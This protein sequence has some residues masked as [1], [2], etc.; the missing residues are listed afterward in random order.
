MIAFF[1]APAS[2]PTELASQSIAAFNIR[3]AVSFIPHLPWYMSLTSHSSPTI[4]TTDIAV[5]SNLLDFNPLSLLA[6]SNPAGSTE[7]T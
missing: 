3:L 6:A 2:I 5:S 4:F 7:T 1:N